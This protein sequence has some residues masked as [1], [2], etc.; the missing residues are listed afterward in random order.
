MRRAIQDSFLIRCAAPAG[1]PS[2]SF[3]KIDGQQPNTMY[4]A[5]HLTCLRCRRPEG[6][7]QQ[8]FAAFGA[9]LGATDGTMEHITDTSWTL[10]STRR[11]GSHFCRWNVYRGSEASRPAVEFIDCSPHRRRRRCGVPKVESQKAPR[12]RAVRNWRS[13][14]VGAVS[15]FHSMPVSRA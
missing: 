5:T 1:L 9:N 10:N 4:A 8:A 14:S 12:D 3:T 7:D 6:R 13:S 11:F 15:E 2:C